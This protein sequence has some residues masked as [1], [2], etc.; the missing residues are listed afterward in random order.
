MGVSI[1]FI[2]EISLLDPKESEFY[3][4]AGGADCTMELTWDL[5]I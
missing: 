2:L 1:D 4:K 3:K 5:L